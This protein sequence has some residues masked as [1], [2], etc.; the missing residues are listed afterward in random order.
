MIKTLLLVFL[1]CKFTGLSGAQAFDLDELEQ[2]EQLESLDLHDA[3]KAAAERDDITEAERLLDQ[4]IGKGSSGDER[5]TRDAIASA[6][7]RIAER[8]RA[9]E[10]KRRAEAER[11]KR[12][13]ER[14]RAARAAAGQGRPSGQ[15]S[16]PKVSCI[17]VDA[18]CTS[19]WGCVVDDVEVS[20]GPGVVDNS[21]SSPSICSDY[22]GRLA[23][24]YGYTMRIGSTVCSGQFRL[25]DRVRS[26]VTV[27]VFSDSCKISYVNE[28]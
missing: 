5:A 2:I 13:A 11:A 17:T 22:K 4:A 27:N 24:T 8:K 14:E 1:L 15:S 12:E 20:G 9:A 25:T 26:G 16:S 23:G 6:R 19:G 21:W 3:A 10:E 7:K 28:Y 18:Q